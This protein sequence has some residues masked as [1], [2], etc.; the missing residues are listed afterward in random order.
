MGQ[1]QPHFEG[2]EAAAC[3]EKGKVLGRVFLLHVLGT[4]QP[5]AA[6][7]LSSPQALLSH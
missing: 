3:G 2:A 5:W 7:Q 4:A 6:G 1:G